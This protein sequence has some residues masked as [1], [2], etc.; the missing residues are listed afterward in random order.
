SLTQSMNYQLVVARNQRNPSAGIQ[1]HFDADK[2]G[3]GIVQ[4]YVLFL[5]WSTSSKDPQNTNADTTFEVKKPEPAVYVSL[6]SCEKTKKHDEKTKN[7][8]AL[9]D[10]TYSD[11][12]EDVGAEADFSNLETNINVSPIPTTRVYKD[13]HVTQ[14]IGDLSSAPQTRSMTKMVKEQDPNWIEAK[15]EELLQ[16]KMPKVWVLVDLRKGHTQEEGMDYEKVFALVSRIEAIRLFLAYA[17]FMGFM[18]YQMDVKSAFLYETIKE[19][20]Y[21]CQPI[22]FEDPDY[23]NKVYKVVKALYGLHQ[24][25]RA[26]RKVIITDDTVRQAL[27]L[28]DAD[29]IDCLPN[30]EIFAELARIR[31]AVGLI[32]TVQLLEKL[33]LQI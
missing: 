3:E 17:S 6:S 29:I 19:E 12:E 16:F 30:E 22:G 28:D 1:E 32:P 33:K 11:D 31:V 15:Q 13:H 14:I 27:R 25:L 18:A 26:W 2:A 23:P 24:A 9:E 20:V 10:I 21:V 4:Q 8:P 5:L 7:L